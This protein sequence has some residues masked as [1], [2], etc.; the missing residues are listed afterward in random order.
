M[1]LMRPSLHPPP[2]M[3]GI[4]DLMIAKLVTGPVRYFHLCLFHLAFVFAL[5]GPVSIRLK[6]VNFL[7]FQT[8]EKLIL[9]FQ[10]FTSRLKKFTST[11]TTMPMLHNTFN[12]VFII[13]ALSPVTFLQPESGGMFQCCLSL[14]NLLVIG[15]NDRLHSWGICVPPRVFANRFRYDPLTEPADI[16][17]KEA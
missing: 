1:V 9:F 13:F 14:L 12:C 16:H 6:L 15:I 2:P 5:P 4:V 8:T 10:I 17:V 7:C 3:L 11:T